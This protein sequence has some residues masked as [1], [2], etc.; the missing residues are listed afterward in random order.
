MS[1]RYECDNDECEK[2]MTEPIITVEGMSRCA[3]I[4]LPAHM[5]VHHFCSKACM[6]KAYGLK[7]DE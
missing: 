7:E 1:Q 3:E 2:Q 4:L 5:L 6:L